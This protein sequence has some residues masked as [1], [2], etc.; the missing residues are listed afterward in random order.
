MPSTGSKD[1]FIVRTGQS[2]QAQIEAHEPGVLASA[3]DL[4]RKTNILAISNW[5]R[6]RSSGRTRTETDQEKSNAS[7]LK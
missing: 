2:E 1:P 4:G 5:I 7:L 3:S 6:T